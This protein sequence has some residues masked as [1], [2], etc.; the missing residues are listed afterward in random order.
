MTKIERFI[1]N[2][3]VIQFLKEKSKKI[4][5]PGFEGVPLYDVSSFFWAEVKKEGL[6]ERAAAI[7]YNFIMAIPPTC[8]FLFTLIPNLPFVP[9]KTIQKQLHD[10]INDIIPAT[11]H[12]G[13]LIKFVDGFF[14]SSRIGLLSFGFLLLIFFRFQRNDGIDAFFQQKLHWLFE[15]NRITIKMDGYQ[16]NL[17]DDGTTDGLPYST[18]H[19]GNGDIQTRIKT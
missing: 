3:P 1:T 11:E 19:A 6:N 13:N 15:E 17:P 12:N 4:I 18:H 2:L 10:V 5:L 16:I 14:G 7:A 8:L 9:T